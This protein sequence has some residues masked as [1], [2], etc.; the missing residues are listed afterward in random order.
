MRW[1]SGR[2]LFWRFSVFR[3]NC[4]ELW[5]IADTTPQFVPATYGTSPPAIRP[6][7]SFEGENGEWTETE[8]M[9]KTVTAISVT[10]YCV[11]LSFSPTLLANRTE[12]GCWLDWIPLQYDFPQLCIFLRLLCPFD[13]RFAVTHF[14]PIPP[15]LAHSISHTLSSFRFQ[16]FSV[17]L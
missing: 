17:S 8:M 4:G 3:M 11:L 7:E 2:R 9:T 15:S 1:L 13:F 10:S 14:S 12:I 6:Q 5:A 16:P